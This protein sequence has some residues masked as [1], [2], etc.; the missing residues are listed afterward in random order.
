M[1][2]KPLVTACSLSALHFSRVSMV[3]W[4]GNTSDVFNCEEYNALTE[5]C[6]GSSVTKSNYNTT[7]G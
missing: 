1:C 7:Q 2:D 4:D 6:L 3:C 5:G